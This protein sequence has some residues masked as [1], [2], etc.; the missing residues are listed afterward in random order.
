MVLEFAKLL[1]GGWE[2]ASSGG[3]YLVMVCAGPVFKPL[4][5][6]PTA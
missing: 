1:S 5:R 4:R 2:K 6:I 3:T